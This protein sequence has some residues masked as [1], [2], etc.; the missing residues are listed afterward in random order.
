MR[1]FSLLVCLWVLAAIGCKS[2]A[3]PAETTKPPE[4][5]TDFVR[6]CKASVRAMLRANIC[7]E[8]DADL[9][10]EDIPWNEYT[11]WNSYNEALAAYLKDCEK[12]EPETFFRNCPKPNLEAWPSC[13]EAIAQAAN[14]NEIADTEHSETCSPVCPETAEMKICKAAN[15][16]AVRYWACMPENPNNPWAGLTEAEAQQKAIYKLFVSCKENEEEFVEKLIAQEKK[17]YHCEALDMETYRG[18]IHLLKA[19]EECK[20]EDVEEA[21]AECTAGQSFCLED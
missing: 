14:C 17:K 3:E 13:Y 2:D 7:Y 12:N 5:E 16:A 15:E 9:N 19:V 1:K 8:R 11:D 10:S 4:P 21:W 6:M 20:E 18:C